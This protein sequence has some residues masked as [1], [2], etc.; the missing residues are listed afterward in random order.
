[1]LGRVVGLVAGL[2]RRSMGEGIRCFLRP[3]PPLRS[4]QPRARLSSLSTSSPPQCRL[5]EGLSRDTFLTGTAT[6]ASPC[7][8]VAKAENDLVVGGERFEVRWS[9]DATREAEMAK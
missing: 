4:D 2:I 7:G 6:R 8:S 3:R 1:M 5:C 9:R